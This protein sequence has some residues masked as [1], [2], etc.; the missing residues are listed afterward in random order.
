MREIIL[1]SFRKQNSFNNFRTDVK[2]GTGWVDSF[3]NTLRDSYNI[4]PNGLI[5]KSL[6]NIWTS[7]G[8]GMFATVLSR[9][10]MRESNLAAISHHILA[11]NEGYNCD[12]AVLAVPAGRR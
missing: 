6:N 1:A 11:T 3:L 4:F 10:R 5:H 2:F 12:D 8:M 9:T 7:L